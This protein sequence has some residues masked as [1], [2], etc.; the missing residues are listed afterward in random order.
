MGGDS[1]GSIPGVFVDSGTPTSCHRAPGDRSNHLPD[2]SRS[3]AATNNRYRKPRIFMNFRI[4][5]GL[6]SLR[7]HSSCRLLGRCEDFWEGVQEARRVRWCARPG[8]G[9]VDAPE[10][11]NTF[12]TRLVLSP[13]VYMAIGDHKPDFGTNSKKDTRFYLII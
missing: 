7:S 6:V 13:P 3:S 1:G 9:G 10:S 12:G 2:T 11:R 8:W 4:F 5:F